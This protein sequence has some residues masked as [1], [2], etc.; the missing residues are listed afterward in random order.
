MVRVVVN[1]SCCW[2]PPSYRED[3]R[4]TRLNFGGLE[5][6]STRCSVKSPVFTPK[7]LQPLAQGREALR[8]HPGK[9]TG[10]HWL[11]GSA[12]PNRSS[13]G[14]RVPQGALAEPRDPGLW[15][16]TPSA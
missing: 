8:A 14:I 13:F 3:S 5:R 10:Y 9:G 11:T 15:N 12:P 6:V 16:R 2:E 7:A 1:R 4:E